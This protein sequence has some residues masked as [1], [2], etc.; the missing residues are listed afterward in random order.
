VV[1]EVL[2]EILVLE[3]GMDVEDLVVEEDLKIHWRH[4]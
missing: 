4:T 2:E 1:V 3:E